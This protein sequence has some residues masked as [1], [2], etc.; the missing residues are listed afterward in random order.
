MKSK[1]LKLLTVLMCSIGLTFA[2]VNQAVDNFFSSMQANVNVPTVTQNQSA[3]VL[4]FGGVSTRSQTINLQPLT[5]TPP[6]FNQSCGN[7]NFYS[8]SLTF[9]TNTDQLIAFLQ[10][11]LMT[12]ALT[13]VMTALK[14]AT[15][16]IAGTLQSTMDAAQKMLGMFNNSCQLGM[17]LG[18]AGYSTV[19]DMF[20]KSKQQSYGDSA[21]A[22]AAEVNATTSG[23]SGS[24]IADKMNK[25]ADNYHDWVNR[26]AAMNPLDQKA[27]VDDFS[28]TY[29][30]I[31]WKG[32][33]T[34]I[35]YKLPYTSVGTQDVANI[36]NLVISLTGD[37]V[38]YPPADNGAGMEARYIQP[39]IIDL[40][41]FM[42]SES[43][44]TD[45]FNCNNFQPTN[46][47]ECTNPFNLSTGSYPKSTYNGSVMKKISGA[48]MDIQKHFINNASL[49]SDDM[50][51]I[52]ASPVPIFAMA[53]TLDDLGMSGS[54]SSYLN[55][56]KEQIAFEIL[57]KLIQIS[58][59]LANEATVSRTNEKTVSSVQSLMSSIGNIQAQLGIYSQQY[60]KKNPA[61][62]M[63]ELNYLQG[64]AQNMMSPMIMQK[65]NYAKQIGSY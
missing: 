33:Q 4:S 25:I 9:M 8:G 59:N 11:T 49:T 1:K 56:Y 64:M 37:V 38:I 57:S 52:A 10:N 63:M 19:S 36:A 35:L 7:M 54:I 2:D 32:M 23:S 22:S 16:N 44:S 28:K 60:V 53:Q 18:N 6:S 42:V 47:G 17:A 14:A 62:I 61:E 3:G 45:V 50:F 15:P 20:T 39:T 26:N 30:S 24:S 65:V 46:P 13:A 5:F 29:G 27:G 41:Q 43:S 12:A 31:L 51:I 55:Y 48:I 40:R 21:D 34:K 58:A